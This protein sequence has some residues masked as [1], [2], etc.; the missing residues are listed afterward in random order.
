MYIDSFSSAV[1]PSGAFYV[2]DLVTEAGERVRAHKQPRSAPR[3][4]TRAHVHA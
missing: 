4:C 2:F 3:A 1:A